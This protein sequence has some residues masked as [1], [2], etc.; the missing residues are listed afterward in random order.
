[1]RVLII[2]KERKLYLL[3][4]G[5]V[6][7]CAPVGL[8]RV[9]EGA[10]AREGD[11]K[12]PEGVYFICLAKPDGKHGRSLGLNYP[13]TA[14]ARA[15]LVMKTIG[16]AAYRA[17]AGAEAGRRRPP[18]GTALGGEIYIHEG[19]AHEDWTQGCIAMDSS[20]MDRLYPNHPQ[21]T[22]VEIRP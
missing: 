9:P 5:S 10:K 13:N 22:L 11:G 18:W 15:A 16:E 14:D 19:G 3:D 8:G 20:G 1:M 4:G 17:I 12:T 21:I 2:K 6:L 7:L